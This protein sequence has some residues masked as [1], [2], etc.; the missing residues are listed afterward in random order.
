[1]HSGLNFHF[2]LLLMHS[3][4]STGFQQKSC[5]AFWETISL[6]CFENWHYC[7]ALVY[8]G[9]PQQYSG[10]PQFAL[11]QGWWSLG[12]NQLKTP[13]LGYFNLHL[14]MYFAIP[15]IS[16]LVS[17]KSCRRSDTESVSREVRLWDGSGHTETQQQNKQSPGSLHSGTEWVKIL[18]APARLLCSPSS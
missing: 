14:T 8:D 3:N 6:F 13:A 12:Q 11:S 15:S 2:H 9:P 1:M 5:C 18:Y 10:G 16:C 4:V 7:V 17:A